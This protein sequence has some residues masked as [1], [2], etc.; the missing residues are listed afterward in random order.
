ME[1]IS[2]SYDPVTLAMPLAE[3]ITRRVIEKGTLPEADDVRDL[4]REL[5]LEEL[6]TGKGLA[7]HRNRHLVA[8]TFPGEPLI[9]DIIP[10]SGE[11]SDAVEVIAYHDRELGAFVVEILPANDLEYEGNIGLEPAIIDEKTLELK[12]SPVFGHFE[13]GKDG[14]HLVIDGKTYEGWKESGKLNVCPI[15]GGE[16]VWRG[17]EALCPECGYGIR[18]VKE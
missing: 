11:L 9:V 14:L 17:K 8:L 10:S 6:Y 13:E 12:S 3:E 7:L 16:L 4:L 18:V 1:R 2:Y 5:G 15:C